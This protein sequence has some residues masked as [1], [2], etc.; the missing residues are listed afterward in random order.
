MATREI[1]SFHAGGTKAGALIRHL[2]EDRIETT[3]AFRI[4]SGPVVHLFQET[5][6]A[7]NAFDWSVYRYVD[8]LLNMDVTV[9]APVPLPHEDPART[10]I[11][12]YAAH[13]VLK[14][15]LDT[16]APRREFRQFHEDDPSTTASAALVRAGS[17]TVETPWGP[18]D[19]EKVVLEVDGR[20]GNT[21][22][23]VD[24]APIKSDWQGATSYVTTD[25]EYVLQGLD[26]EVLCI[27]KADLE[28][29]RTAT[30]TLRP[31]R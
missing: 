27:L 21:F 9:Q 1:N 28:R 6:F 4:H 31:P 5:R 18:R 22:W 30:G 12:S 23:C 2:S 19:A 15:L 24:G 13:L 20:A 8:R 3:L 7:A 17:E 10:P 11:P 14:D 16:A 29:T 25:T 26:P